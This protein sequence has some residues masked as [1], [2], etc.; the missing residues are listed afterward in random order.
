MN[1]LR[2]SASPIRRTFRPTVFS[3]K[4]SAVPARPA[5]APASACITPPSKPS[6]SESSRPTLPTEPPTV[7]PLHRQFSNPFVTASNGQHLGQYFPV[8]FAPLNSSSRNPDPNVD[9]SQYVPISGI[10]AYP[11][12]NRI[13]YTEQYMFSLER[14]VGDNTLFSASYVGNQSHRLLVLVESNPGDPALCLSLSQTSQVASGS[15]TCGP[16]G[17]SNVFTTASGQTVNGTRGPL[18]PNFGSNTNQSTIGNSNYN[19]LELSLRHTS[20]R[21]QL[22]ASYTFSKSIDQSSNVGEEVNPVNPSAQPCL[23]G[24]RREAQLCGELRLRASLRA[25]IRCLQSLDQRLDDFRHHAFQQRFSGNAAQLRRQFPA[26]SG[27]ERHQQ[28]RRG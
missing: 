25:S 13:P 26:G 16:F 12:N 10:P 28:L 18:G 23:V 4:S 9:W 11:V 2:A 21:L 7:V 14:Q 27:A 6:P 5:F 15:A 19:A 24:V 20:K 3:A 1:F 8:T 17:E 22:F